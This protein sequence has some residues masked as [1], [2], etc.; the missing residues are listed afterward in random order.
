MTLAHQYLPV[1][2]IQQKYFLSLNYALLYFLKLDK[3]TQNYL[4]EYSIKVFIL[5]WLYYLGLK[6]T[7]HLY[8]LH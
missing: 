4:A 1:V 3:Y 8:S 2:L 7:L 5:E 6:T